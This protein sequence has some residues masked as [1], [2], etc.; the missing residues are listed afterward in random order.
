MQTVLTG[1]YQAHGAVTE[2]LT[3][4]ME[5]MK[6]AVVSHFNHRLLETYNHSWSY[7]SLLSEVDFVTLILLVSSHT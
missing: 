3:V 1:V 7:I 2:R 6:M 5:L 4:R